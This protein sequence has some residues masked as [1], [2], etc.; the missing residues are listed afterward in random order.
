MATIT[1]GSTTYTPALVQGYEAAY[2]VNTLQHDLIGNPEPEYTFQVG[3]LRRGSMSLVFDTLADAAACAAAHRMPGVF[4]FTDPARPT[5]D[6]S[7]VT[8]PGQEVRVAQDPTSVTRA[9][10]V[11]PFHE[12]TP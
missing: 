1:N 12:V 2:Q 8:A 3:S 10:L 9:T 7:Y 4:V 11:V 5:A 6:M